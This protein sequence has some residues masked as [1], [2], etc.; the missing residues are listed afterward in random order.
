MSKT[1]QRRDDAYRKGY[2]DGLSGKK[3][4]P[5]SHEIRYY[6]RGYGRGRLIRNRKKPRHRTFTNEYMD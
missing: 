1:K 5:T 3:S 2:L 6:L 4:T